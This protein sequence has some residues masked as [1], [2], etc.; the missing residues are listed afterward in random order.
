MKSKIFTIKYAQPSQYQPSSSKKKSIPLKREIT[1]MIK[2]VKLNNAKMLAYRHE[3]FS[4][5]LTKETKQYM[6]NEFTTAPNPNDKNAPSFNHSIL[7]ISPEN[8]HMIDS[9]A[10]I[11][12]TLIKRNENQIMKRLFLLLSVIVPIKRIISTKQANTN[13]PTFSSLM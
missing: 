6:N 10:I 4:F 5:S 11:M 12:I 7:V 8:A 2:N 1:T 9:P 3:T 13:N